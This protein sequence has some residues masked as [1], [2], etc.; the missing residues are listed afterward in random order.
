MPCNPE[1]TSLEAAGYSDRQSGWG[2]Q[3]V[4]DRYDYLPKA[5]RAPWERGWWMAEWEIFNAKVEARK[6]G[7]ENVR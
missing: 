4:A 7:A 2:L 3:S 6:E 5:D 1:T